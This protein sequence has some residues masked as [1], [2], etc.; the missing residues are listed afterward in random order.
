MLGEEDCCSLVCSSGRPGAWGW[1]GKLSRADLP[2]EG[3]RDR[4][5]GGGGFTS[6]A[7]A[8]W[9]WCCWIC[10]CRL[11]IVRAT[12]GLAGGMTSGQ[13]GWGAAPG[14]TSTPAQVTRGLS[15]GEAAWQ[16]HHQRQPDKVG[17]GGGQRPGSVVRGPLLAAPV[18]SWV[19]KRSA[20]PVASAAGSVNVG[21]P[22]DGRETSADCKTATNKGFDFCTLKKK[23][24]RFVGPL[25]MLCFK[26]IV[27]HFQKETHLSK[28][29][30]MFIYF[31]CSGSSLLRVSFL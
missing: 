22:V 29:F 15:Q 16:S 19:R 12:C 2:A 5:G 25:T 18:V 6:R 10:C 14:S 26:H 13:Q 7:W 30:L 8:S 24:P 9:R 31:G 1:G 23:W 4:C 17:G 20:G 28:T 11:V 27:R 21:M 3:C